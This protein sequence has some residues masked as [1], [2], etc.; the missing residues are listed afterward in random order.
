MW[1]PSLRSTQRRQHHIDH[2]PPVVQALVPALSRSVI[3]G[4]V[5]A[6]A[7]AAGYLLPGRANRSPPS[8]LGL[9]RARGDAASGGCPPRFP[10]LEVWRVIPAVEPASAE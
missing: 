10:E 1:M 2:V 9:R 3:R 7:I 8:R 4:K 6:S 5:Y